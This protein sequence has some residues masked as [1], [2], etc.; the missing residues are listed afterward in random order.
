MGQETETQGGTL[1]SPMSPDSLI[2]ELEV[3]TKRLDFQAN[4]LCSGK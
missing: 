4:I 2:A 1:N 3:E